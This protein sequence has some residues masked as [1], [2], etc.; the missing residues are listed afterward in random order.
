M[1]TVVD[2][3]KFYAQKTGIKPEAFISAAHTFSVDARMREADAR[4]R[5]YQ[6]DGTPTVIVDGKYRLT[7]QSAGGNEPFIRLVKWLVAQRIAHHA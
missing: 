5:A 4:I 6:A 7:P 2:V 3:A 1:P